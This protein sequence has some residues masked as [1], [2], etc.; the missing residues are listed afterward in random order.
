MAKGTPV[1]SC[2]HR[3]LSPI[4]GMVES[5]SVHAIFGDFGPCIS[6]VGEH[7]PE[8]LVGI[9][10]PGESEAQPNHGDGHGLFDVSDEGHA[11]FDSV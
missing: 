6:T 3:S 5:V 9:G 10:A 11:G 1:D 4:I 2:T 8:S 7:V